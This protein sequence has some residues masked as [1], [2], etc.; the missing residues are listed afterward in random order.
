MGEM[1]PPA[2]LLAR[3]QTWA[4]SVASDW[5]GVS[6]T[7][8]LESPESR[9]HYLKVGDSRRWPNGLA[10][11]ER[12][13]WAAPFLPVAEVVDC[14]TDES[15]DWLLTVAL[16]GVDA[17]RHALIGQPARLV[18]VLAEGLAQFHAA[19]LVRLCPFDFGIE[20]ALTHVRSRASAGLIDPESDFHP[21]HRHLSVEAALAQLELLTPVDEDLVVC[22]GDYCLPNVMLGPE[23]TVTGYLDLGELGVADRWWDL[24]I[25]S[26]SVTWNLGPGWEGHFLSSYGVE[27]DSDRIRFYR[28]LYDLVS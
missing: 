8:R 19:A 20:A 14:G 16:A 13:R 15:V 27:P 2:D 4:W 25:G 1:S 7:W 26:W 28:L 3:Y 11:C 5:P 12:L 9:V 6:T 17:T 23:G 22:H 21:E 10:E 18:A 24:A